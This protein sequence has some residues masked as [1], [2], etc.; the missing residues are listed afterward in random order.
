M[1]RLNSGVRRRVAIGLKTK[2]G[3][4]TNRLRI[5]FKRMGIRMNTSTIVASGRTVLAGIATLLMLSAC[6]SAAVRFYPQPGV[7]PESRQLASEESVVVL[8]G[9]DVPNC[10]L[11][12]LGT[13][14]Y[15]WARDGI[16]TSETV[17]IDG[18]REYAAELGATGIY[19]VEITGGGVAGTGSMVATGTGGVGFF[20]AGQEVG[21]KA[22]AYVCN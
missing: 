22:V 12:E 14:S 13:L 17:V 10:D 18:L 8:L 2:L 19:K 15:D 16:F 9:R 21:G 20:G 5:Q 3:Y 6:T 7:N 11:T 1:A 4:F